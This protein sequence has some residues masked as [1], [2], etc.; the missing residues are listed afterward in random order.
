M[1]QVTVAVQDPLAAEGEDAPL[2][3]GSY[4]R[5]VIS[6]REA[7]NVAELP[8]EAIREG[9]IVWVVDENQ[10]L[11]DEPVSVVFSTPRT[12]LVRGLEA[13]KH[14]VVS[15]LDGALRGELVTIV[16]PKQAPAEE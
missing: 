2:L 3:L 12:V 11:L 9:E 6:G 10:T 4:V 13:G 5:V 7:S 16:E 14:V 15:P 1:A 8:A